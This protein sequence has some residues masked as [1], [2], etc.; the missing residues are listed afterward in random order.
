MVSFF[1][2]ILFGLLINSRSYSLMNNRLPI[3]HI[4]LSLT[5]ILNLGLILC[6]FTFRSLSVYLFRVINIK[7]KCYEKYDMNRRNCCHFCC[8]KMPQRL[9][10]QWDPGTLKRC[11]GRFALG[12]NLFLESNRRDFIL[13]F[14]SGSSAHD[15][16]LPFMAQIFFR[17]IWGRSGDRC[18]FPLSIRFLSRF[19]TVSFSLTFISL[20][21]SLSLVQIMFA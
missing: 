9:S 3:H 20:P 1:S 16:N 15:L 12:L 4:F 10:L 5:V 11:T 18:D 2:I 21:F 8:M 6:F 7:V 13:F 19:T 14:L 17:F